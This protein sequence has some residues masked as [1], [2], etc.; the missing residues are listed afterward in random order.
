MWTISC[1]IVEIKVFFTTRGI[2]SPYV[3]AVTAGRLGGSW[4]DSP[5][6]EKIRG[7]F[8]PTA[9]IPR[10]CEKFRHEVF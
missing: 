6:A 5:P 1:R 3:T 8:T 9:R 2:C 4:G 10:L 7:C